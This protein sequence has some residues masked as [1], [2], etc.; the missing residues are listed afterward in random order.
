M[1]QKE[2]DD[3]ATC[4]TCKIEYWLDIKTGH[5]IDKDD[6]SILHVCKSANGSEIKDGARNYY[7]EKEKKIQELAEKSHQQ[8]SRRAILLC[9]SLPS[10]YYAQRKQESQL[11]N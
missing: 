9:Q 8:G 3:M 1:W 5:K 2:V 4:N 6:H 10:N 7:E 11:L